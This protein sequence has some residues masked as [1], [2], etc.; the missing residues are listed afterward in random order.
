[1]KK[2]MFAPLALA[3]LFAI[4]TGSHT[5]AAAHPTAPQIGAC[6][7]FCG[8]G[9]TA[10]KTETACEQVCSTECVAVC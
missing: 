3:A 8:P 1:M 2:L 9:S 5:P 7:W 6:R 4:A 10:F